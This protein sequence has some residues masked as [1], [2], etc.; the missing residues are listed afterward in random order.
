[1]TKQILKINNLSKE[2]IVN[3]NKLPIL[4]KINFNLF[5][6][7]IVSISGP[8]GSGKSTLIYIIG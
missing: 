8:S 2:Y 6:G 1:M 3:K 7:D 4:T 5:H